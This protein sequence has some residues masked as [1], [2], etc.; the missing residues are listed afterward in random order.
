MS[1]SIAAE[2]NRLK[3][4]EQASAEIRQ[5]GRTPDGES[6]QATG[7]ETPQFRA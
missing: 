3:R 7:I 2:Y 6:E 1:T 4:T 5:S